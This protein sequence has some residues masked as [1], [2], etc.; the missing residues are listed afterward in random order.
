MT[1]VGPPDW[2]MTAFPLTRD[3]ISLADLDG[4]PAS[5]QIAMCPYGEAPYLS[6]RPGREKGKI[7]VCSAASGRYRSNFNHSYARG[8]KK[9]P[10]SSLPITHY[11][12]G[13]YKNHTC[14]AGVADQKVIPFQEK[15]KPVDN[16]PP[17]APESISPL[18]LAT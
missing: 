1:L 3:M 9:W 7:T 18:S 10:N 13:S 17:A 11:L 12:I 2:P 5:E 15:R 6:D 4:F 16:L 14:K 8:T